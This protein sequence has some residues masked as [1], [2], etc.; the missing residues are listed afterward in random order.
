M[1]KQAYEAFNRLA[2][3][4]HQARGSEGP[5]T[6]TEA[7]Q[8]AAEYINALMEYLSDDELVKAVD[9]YRAGQNRIKQVAES[10]KNWLDSEAGKQK[11]EEFKEFIARLSSKMGNVA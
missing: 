11:E 3:K 9:E 8:L 5:V 6:E 10:V 2:M 7:A 1:Y 4:L